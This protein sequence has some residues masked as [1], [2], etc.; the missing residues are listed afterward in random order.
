MF[1]TAKNGHVL[2]KKGNMIL[3]AA[4]PIKLRTA[5]RNKLFLN[6]THFIIKM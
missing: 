6:V 3:F 2:K 1:S 4:I 5:E